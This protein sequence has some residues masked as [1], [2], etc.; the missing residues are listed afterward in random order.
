MILKT[1][2]GSKSQEIHSGHPLQ[3]AYKREAGRGSLR[4]WGK[5]LE[6]HCT[7]SLLSSSV[8]IPQRHHIPSIL[9]GGK[10]APYLMPTHPRHCKDRCMR[11]PTIFG[12]KTPHTTAPT[13]L[14]PHTTPLPPHR[15][16]LAPEHGPP[17]LDRRRARRGALGCKLVA[18][19]SLGGAVAHANV[20]ITNSYRGAQVAYSS[21][22]WQ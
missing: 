14:L 9:L 2:Q 6:S 22:R 19:L 11:S 12:T 16:W 20:V 3:E 21:V 8:C 7:K 13:P 5:T 4:R 10:L 17:L 18:K 15:R 1:A